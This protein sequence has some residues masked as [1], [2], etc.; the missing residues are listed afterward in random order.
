MELKAWWRKAN[1]ECQKEAILALARR[2]VLD[3][4]W[5]KDSIPNWVTSFIF[6]PAPPLTK[7]LC[8]VKPVNST[9]ASLSEVPAPHQ[10]PSQLASTSLPASSPASIVATGSLFFS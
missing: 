9:N 4:P 10:T 1:D 8:S 3:K 6:A 5:L 2:K 7:G